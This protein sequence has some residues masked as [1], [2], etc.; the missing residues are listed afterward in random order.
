VAKLSETNV[1]PGA[2][3]GELLKRLLESLAAPAGAVW[4]RT[5]QGHLQLQYQINLKEVGLE[6]SEETRKSHDELLRQAMTQ[7]KPFHLPPH[8]GVGQREEGKTPAGN[9]TD[10]LLMVSPIMVNQQVSGL[11]EVWQ[12]ANR[13]PQAI[14]GYLQYM[15]FMS[16]LASRYQRNQLMGQLTGQQQVWTQLEA[17]A[18]QV[19]TSLHPVEVAYT[20]ANEG[21]RLV[22]CDRVTV[23]VRYGSKARIEA[24]SGADVVETR[25]NLVRLMRTL[26]ERVLTWGEKLVFNGTRDDSLPPKV[27]AALDA[28]L[29]ESNSKLLVV[30]PLRDEREKESKKPP[31]AAILMECFEP[32]AEPQQL[33]ARLDVIARHST[34]AL[35]NA[36]E[37]RRIPMRMVWLPL[38]KLQE[39]IGGKAKAISAVAVALLSLLGAAMYFMPYQLK[40]ETNG[41]LVPAVRRVVYPPTSGTIRDFKVDPGDPLREDRQLARLFSLELEQRL[42]TLADAFESAIYEANQAEFNSRRPGLPHNEKLNYLDKAEIQRK[43]A[44]LKKQEFDEFVAR[45]HADAVNRGEFELLAPPFTAEERMR[46]NRAEWTVLNGNFR[47][48]WTNRMAKPSDALLRLG[49]K[50]GP[51][52]I[53]LRIPQKHI[54][55]IL[56]AYERNGGQP[57]DIDF[58]LRSDPTRTYRGKLYRDKIASEAVP[59]RDEKDESEPEVIAFA[60]I[61]DSNIDPNYRLSRESLTSGTEVHAKVRCGKH[62]LGYALFYGVWEFIYE[63]VVFFF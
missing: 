13:P 23:A 33:I 9:P 32:P 4:A 16:E 2:F 37:H 34:P 14:T 47:D 62:R 39:G 7:T 57:L 58:L 15:T 19:H 45:N 60:S 6:R 56:G 31:R 18:R 54:S 8:S 27:L 53:E 36:V 59:N 12:G 48:E 38:A 63:K 44:R 30:Q 46:V 52:E 26:C 42:N 41:K 1:P 43:L 40:M 29:A 17:F 20:V 35:Y 61:D 21:R 28:Y 55:Q 10:Y 3:Y 25:S 5:A 50:D 24:V 51:W 11:V 22:E 49:A